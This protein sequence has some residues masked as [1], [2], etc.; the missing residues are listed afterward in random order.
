VKGEYSLL[1]I[2]NVEGVVHLYL[3]RPEVHNA[4]DGETIKQLIVAFEELAEDPAARVIVLGGRGKSFCAGADLKWMMSMAMSGAQSNGDDAKVLGTLFQVINSSPKPVIAR[5]HGAVRGGGL[6]IVAACDIPVATSNVTFAFT[7]V[8]LGLAPAVI[9]PFCIARI[10]ASA[11]RE[12]FLTGAKF[13]AHR[14]ERL[15]LVHHVAEDEEALDAHIAQLTTDIIK[16]G[17]NALAA[18][19]RLA[20]NVSSMG[21]EEAFQYTSSMI[22]EL[23]GGAEGKEG[24]S[25]FMQRRKP[26]WCDE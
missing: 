2:Q 23:R 24:M 4:F 16:G 18:C 15:S 20:M 7:E 8:R 5:V 11:A 25:A 17:P 14:A 9:S 12:L 19:K 13:D 10:G 21:D 22:A 6:G 3:N 26:A 1:D